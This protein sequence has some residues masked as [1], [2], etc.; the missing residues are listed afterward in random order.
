MVERLEASGRT[1]LMAEVGGEIV[2][3]GLNPNGEVWRLGVEKPSEHDRAIH[4]VVELKDAAMATSG[5]YRNYYEVDGQ[6]VSHLIDPR[7]MQPITHRLASVTVIAPKCSTADGWATA[8][9][10]MGE[11]EGLALANELG[12]AA[13]F[14]VRDAEGTFSTQHSTS[15]DAL[16]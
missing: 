14:I 3:R 7:T 12:L 6:R 13:L 4:E 1:D 11:K 2:A 15:F 5:D 16:K 10:V 8:L 9:S